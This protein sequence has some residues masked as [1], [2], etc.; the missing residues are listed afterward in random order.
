MS[1]E[2]LQK[3]QVASTKD[4][5]QEMGEES[6]KLSTFLKDIEELCLWHG[7]FF[8]SRT[9]E[10]SH[11]HA[12][13]FGNYVPGSKGDWTF[14]I[15]LRPTGWFVTMPCNGRNGV[16]DE[17]FTKSAIPNV[18]NST[19]HTKVESE[20]C[21]RILVWIDEGLKQGVLASNSGRLPFYPANNPKHLNA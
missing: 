17:M 8:D 21:D 15:E 2:I 13:K 14:S 16:T 10:N 18:V 12:I 3:Y 20:F 19:N 6:A 5:I 11:S 4:L 7:K 9:G 1:Q